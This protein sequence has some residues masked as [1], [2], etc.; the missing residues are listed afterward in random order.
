MSCQSNGA[1]ASMIPVRPA[2]RNWNRKRAAEQHRRVEADAAAVHRAEP[3]EDLDPGRHRHQ[4]GRGGEERV[5]ACCPCPPRTCDGPRRPWPTKPMP[6][7]AATMHRVA[8]DHLAREHR[9]DLGDEAE[10]R[11]DQDVDLGM[12]EEPE[13]VLPEDGRATGLRV[14][15]VRAQEAIEQQHDLGGRQRRQDDER[16]ARTIAR[17][18]HTKRGMRPS[19]MPGHAHGEDRGD[20]VDARSRS[21]RTPLTRMRQ[22]P[23]VGALPRRE[24]AA[25]QRRVG[26]PADVGRRAGAVQPVAAEK[27]K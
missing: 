25:G 4:H 13:E 20:Q 21:S 9:D 22:I 10:A 24:G 11:H 17:I 1:T 5:R 7:V 14:E 6:I 3:V 12:A 16:H 15:E 26:E 2:H 19:V 18:I 8:E 27:L 23:V